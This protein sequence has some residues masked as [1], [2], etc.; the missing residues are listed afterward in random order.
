MLAAIRTVRGE[1]WHEVSARSCRDALTGEGALLLSEVDIS[2]LKR[3]EARA[4]HLARHDSLTGLPNRNFVIESFSARLAEAREAGDEAALLFIDLDRFKHLNDSLGHSAG[5]E[6]LV[7]TAGRLR[8]QL[9]DG[10][11][12]ARLGGDEFVALIVA[13]CVGPIVEALGRRLIEVVSLPIRLRGRE[14]RVTPSIGLSLFP[15][16]GL[17][18][19]TLMRHA[20]LAMYRA[21]ER[22]RNRAAFFAPEMNTAVQ[23]RMSLETELRAALERREFVVHYQPRLCLNGGGMVGVEA[24]VRWQHPGRGLVLPGVFIAVCE[25]SGLIGALGEQVFEAAALQQR[26]WHG[27]G[28]PLRVSVNISPRQF[29]DAQLPDT[30]ERIVEATGCDPAYME[31]EV[32]ESVLLGQD[33]DTLAVVSRLCALGFGIAVD[34]FGRVGERLRHRLE[35]ERV[36]D[37]RLGGAVGLG[38]H[39]GV[40]WG[41][42]RVR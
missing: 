25:D 30:V 22:G 13:P 33:D 11:L 35:R 32:T 16:D 7:T 14:V 23:T 31:L 20:D 19:D 24:L 42:R 36:E 27:A 15:R 17:E 18:V 4:H 29:A 34:D 39:A 37:Q 6:V 40:R 38:V 26:R 41:D 10:D 28:M 2:E 3:T 8:A 1:R 21:K 12:A 9:R 5:D